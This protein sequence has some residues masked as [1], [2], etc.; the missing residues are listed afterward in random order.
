MTVR[1]G[2]TGGGIRL[3]VKAYAQ[4]LERAAAA[5]R[6]FNEVS[7]RLIFMHPALREHGECEEDD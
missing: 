1:I 4:G 6:S 7:E 2:S 5:I 3:D